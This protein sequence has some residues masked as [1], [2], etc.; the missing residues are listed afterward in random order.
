MKTCTKCGERKPLEDFPKGSRYSDG[1]RSQ[2]KACTALYDKAYNKSY[3]QSKA[4]KKLACQSNI[5]M[6]GE[7]GFTISDAD[8]DAHWNASECAL[9]G[10]TLPVGTATHKH[11]DHKHGT[12]IYRGTLC[13]GCNTSLGV[14]EKMLTNPKLNDYLGGTL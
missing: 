4:G 5:R 14:Y 7:P 9:C 2:C 8:W 3:R 13:S 12:N 1:R 6:R 11:F 10:K